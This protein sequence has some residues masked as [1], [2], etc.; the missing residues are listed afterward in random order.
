MEAVEEE[1][2]CV[3]KLKL[4]FSKMSCTVKWLLSPPELALGG[5]C[6]PA[7]LGLSTSLPFQCLWP[8]RPAPAALDGPQALC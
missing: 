8:I 4:L 1:K 7:P 5:G 3:L 2:V 6:L